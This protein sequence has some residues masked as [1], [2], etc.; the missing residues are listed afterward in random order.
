MATPP[1]APLQGLVRLLLLACVTSRAECGKVPVVPMEGS[2]WLSMKDV[3]RKL[4]DAGHQAVV[5][6]PEVTV[7]LKGEDFFT[8]KT[9]IFCYTE[10][11]Y[12]DLMLS[13]IKLMFETQHYLKTFFKSMAMLRNVSVIYDRSCVEML[14][15]HSLISQLNSSS[16]NVVSLD[17]LFPFGA[18][19]AMYLRIPG[20]FFLWASHVAWTLRTHCLNPPSYIPQLLTT[21]SDHMSLLQRVKNMLCSFP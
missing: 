11:E 18:T 17:P 6:S 20:V 14:H 5:L 7:H 12:N 21:Y 13:H 10:D 1:Q 19:L 16:F 9:Y 3:V 15:D 2:H 8:L 4:H